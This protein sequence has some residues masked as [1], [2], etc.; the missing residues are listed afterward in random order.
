MNQI[1]VEALFNSLLS[2]HSIH[3]NSSYR[4]EA[5]D[6]RLTRL[7]YIAE[8]TVE[9]CES[10][11]LWYLVGKKRVEWPLL[12]CVVIT[13]TTPKWES[14]F[15][16]EIHSGAKR[17]PSGEIGLF[18]LHSQVT[19]IPDSRWRITP[20]EWASA[21]GTS[22]EDTKRQVSLGLRVIGWHVY[23]CKIPYSSKLFQPSRLFAEYH[24]P[25]GYPCAVYKEEIVVLPK[26][27]V[28]LGILAHPPKSQAKWS[29]IDGMSRAR[30]KSYQQLLWKLRVS[31]GLDSG[32]KN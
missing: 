13:A 21:K 24:H 14:G 6:S 12:G 26:G 11:P 20:D 31:L 17:G 32:S 18:Q 9:G 19:H 5:E 7:H 27:S 30:A 2:Y 3:V 28:A 10:H 15:L 16:V 4:N 29:G 1:L 23:R 25:S 22:L 8:A